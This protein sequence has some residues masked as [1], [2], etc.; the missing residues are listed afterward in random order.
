MKLQYLIILLI[1]GIFR[2]E[3]QAMSPRKGG[4]SGGAAAAPILD[5]KRC[6]LKPRDQ[7]KITLKDKSGKVHHLCV[8]SAVCEGKKKEVACSVGEREACPDARKCSPVGVTEDEKITIVGKCNMDLTTHDKSSYKTSTGQV[9]SCEIFKYKL[10]IFLPNKEQ[11]VEIFHEIRGF[12]D[13][14]S[15]AGNPSNP[16]AIPYKIILNKNPEGRTDINMTIN[17]ISYEKKFVPHAYFSS[18]SEFNEG[19]PL[20]VKKNL[21]FIFGLTQGRPWEILNISESQAHKFDL[22]MGRFNVEGTYSVKRP[23]P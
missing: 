3:S 7:T 2:G 18:D 15:S 5:V 13:F 17:G 12:S 21:K 20:G 14:T 11:S 16:T 9:N 23:W 22:N 10:I 4:A 19:D 1:L 8:G 6:D